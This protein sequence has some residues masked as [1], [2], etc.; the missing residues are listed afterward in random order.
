MELEVDIAYEIK[1]NYSQTLKQS[2][3]ELFRNSL[4]TEV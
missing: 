3:E 1:D 2:L 4:Q